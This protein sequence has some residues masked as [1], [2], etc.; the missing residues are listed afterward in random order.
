MSE[1]RVYIEFIPEHYVGDTSITIHCKKSEYDK[2]STLKSLQQ[3]LRIDLETINS[4]RNARTDANAA[5]GGGEGGY[6]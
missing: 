1:S 4:I 3:R 5:A 2:Y 6:E